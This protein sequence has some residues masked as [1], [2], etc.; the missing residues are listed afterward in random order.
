MDINNIQSSHYRFTNTQKTRN[1][2]GSAFLDV[3]AK[4]QSESVTSAENGTVS[5]FEEMVNA[6]YPG[7]ILHTMDTGRIDSNLWRR[8]D[9]PHEAFL[10]QP[11]DESVLDWRPTGPNPSG[12]DSEVQARWDNL[13]GKN[14]VVIPPAL[15]EKMDKD[16]EIAKTVLGK[17]ESLMAWEKSFLPNEDK[18]I[19]MSFIITFDENGEIKDKC[20]TTPGRGIIGPSLQE[21]RD[22]V[23]QRKA[24][25][26]KEEE[27]RMNLERMALR[28]RFE[29]EIQQKQLLTEAVA[30]TWRQ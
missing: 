21:Q 6:R 13:V 9:Y 7:I 29:T 4:Q 5:R 8:N 25:K 28:R 19:Q 12:L 11:V 10:K 27:Y 30:D 20:V 3:V 1:G 26:E 17:I 23:G 15:Q 22:F 2:S 24:K 18:N 14:A 16:P